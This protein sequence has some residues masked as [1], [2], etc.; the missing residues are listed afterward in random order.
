MK[1]DDVGS[2]DEHRALARRLYEEAFGK[3]HLDA[4]DEILAPDCVSHGA[5]GP[6]AVGTEQIK[7]QARLLRTAFPDLET[8]CADQ[9]AE[10]DRV[11]SRWIGRGTFT[12]AFPGAE[13]T[14]GAIHFEEIRIDRFADDRIVESWFIPDRLTLWQQIGLLP[15][16]S[17]QRPPG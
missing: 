10:G 7:R 11:A 12:G 17:D 13:P 15:R 3:G 6:P 14:G 9:I 1:E 4:A 8:I 16:Q 5:G 2:R